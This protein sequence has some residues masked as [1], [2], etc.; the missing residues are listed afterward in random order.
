MH[1]RIIMFSLFII[2]MLLHCAVFFCV[3]TSLFVFP[4]ASV[5]PSLYILS[6]VVVCIST[7]LD[8]FLVQLL[9][10]KNAI[11][12]TAIYIDYSIKFIFAVLYPI[13]LLSVA[14]LSFTEKWIVFLFVFLFFVPFFIRRPK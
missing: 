3:V 13:G 14:Q 1:R 10:R 11:P 7:W 5:P 9:I 12:N 4:E 8:I 6:A 2:V